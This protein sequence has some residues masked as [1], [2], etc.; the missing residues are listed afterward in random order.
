MNHIDMTEYEH[1]SSALVEQFNLQNAV[2]LFPN[3][4][5]YNE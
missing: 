4:L 2:V 1:L 5:K 3:I